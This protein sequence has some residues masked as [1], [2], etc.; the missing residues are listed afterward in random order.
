MTEQSADI[1]RNRRSH[2]IQH[3]DFPPKAARCL[4]C[5]M[6]GLDLSLKPC[7]MVVGTGAERPADEDAFCRQMDRFDR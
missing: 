4:L 5:D 6:T 7:P 1:D 2:A 3:R